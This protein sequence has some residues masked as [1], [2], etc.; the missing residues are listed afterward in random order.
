MKVLVTGGGGFLGRELCKQLIAQG[1]EVAYLARNAYPDLEEM[2]AKGFRIDLG[3]ED[4]LEPALEGVELIYHAASKTGIHGAKSEFLRINTHGTERLLEA[5]KKAGIRRFVYTSSPSVVFSRNCE[6]ADESACQYLDHYDDAY[7]ETKSLAERAVL[8]AN[9]ENFATVALRP[10]L[11]WGPGDP[12]LIPR[13][14]A[15]QKDGRLKRVGDGKNRVS[16]TY[17]ANAAVAHLQ[18]AKRLEPQSPIAGKAYFITDAE[19]V[20]LWPWIDHLLT[21]LGLGPVKSSVP[22]A[23]AY[24]AGACTEALHALLRKTSEPT[25]TRFLVRELSQS[26]W[27]SI[28]AARRDLGY[29]PIVTPEEGLE[30]TIQSFRA[31]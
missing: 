16:I 31:L 6:G 27:Y 2:G 18:A 1:D 11:I 30:R 28:E 26:H 20:M 14:I 15:R 3:S 25:L 23:L 24:F 13:L 21:E 19:P 12:N 5:A 29:A 8:A 4:P 10:H 22:Y 7:A 17:V 9:S